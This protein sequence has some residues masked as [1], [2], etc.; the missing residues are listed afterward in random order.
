MSQTQ[1]R[2]GSIV[3]TR[4][5][6]PPRTAP[7]DTGVWYVSGLA[8]RGVTNAPVLCQ[9][10]Q[11]FINNFGARQTYSVLYDAVETFFREGGSQVWVSRVVGP[12]AVVA[13]VNLLDN[14]AAVSL[15][16]TAKKGAG[17]WANTLRIAV[18][19]GSAGAGSFTIT[20]SDTVLGQLEVSPDLFSQADAIAWS[21]Q[22]QYISLALGASALIPANI[23]SAALTGGADDRNNIVEAQWTAALGRFTK[24]L[25]PGQVSAP[26]RSTTAAH[27]ALLA[28]AAANNRTAL[29][30]APDSP[31]I[32][33]VQA[34][35]SAQR[36]TN[37]TYGGLFAPWLVIPGATAGTTRIVPPSAGVAAKIAAN[38]AMGNSPNAPAAGQPEGVFSYVIGLSQ[39]T[40]DNGNG[41]DVTRDS[42][43][44]AG[45]NQITYRYGQ[46]MVFGWRTLT[47]ENGA[48]A[49]YLN[50]GNS[51]L[52]MAISARALFLA[53]NYI[54]DE[55][56]PVK[57]GRYRGDIEAMLSA[58]WPDSLYGDTPDQAFAVDTGPQVN[59]P[60]TIAN[61]ELHAAI[62]VRMSP[63]SELV[64]IDITKV[65]VTQS[66]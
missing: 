66:L 64:V 33:T 22:S 4:V 62:A 60:V 43:Y 39:P 18:A 15:V 47:A 61:R 9:N 54:L 32:A 40:Y 10:L 44:S 6:P 28:H 53:E 27:A 13:S 19:T 29:L 45:V 56:N 38:E 52:R 12:A 46:Y 16:A 23:A 3:T 48:N 36:G 35:A 49:E 17:A 34:A 57:L 58:Y 51:R 21:Q 25:G 24:D 59:T 1:P 8:D 30:D 50:L 37:D 65:P 26:G 14:A 20:V 55:I 63:D 42:M 31:T 41:K 2:P 11:D 7:V 5:A